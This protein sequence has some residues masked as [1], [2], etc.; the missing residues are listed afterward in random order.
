[1]SDALLI[2]MAANLAAA[3]AV[4]LVMILRTPARKMF[5][6]RLAYGLWLLVPLAALGVLLPSRVVTVT[7]RAASGQAAASAPVADHA[8]ALPAPAA[9]TFD[10]WPLALGVWIA[11]VVATLAWMSWRQA[12]FGRDAE[13]GLAGPAAVGV[14]KPRVITPSDFRRRY[15]AREQFVVLAHEETHI[16]RHD[17]RINALVT[18][19]RCVNWFNPMLHAMARFLRI[20]QE[21]AC[22]AQVIARHPKVRRAYAEAML[23]T[24]LAAQPLP[25]GCYWLPAGQHPLAERIRLLSRAA[26]DPRE[27]IL[28]LTLLTTLALAALGATWAAK[29]TRVQFV[30]LPAPSAPPPLALERI[31]AADPPPL[32]PMS[33]QT[34]RPAAPARVPTPPAPLDPGVALAQAQADA[35]A[36]PPLGG[37]GRDRGASEPGVDPKPRPQPEPRPRRILTAAGR[38]SVEPGSAVRVIASTTDGEG[39]A[40]MTDL[41]SFGS[42]HYYRTGTFI[43]S[44]SRER[45]FTRVVQSGER[46]WVTAGLDPRLDAEDSVTVEM[47]SG[48]TREVAL[49][50]GRAVTL[51]PLMRPET[52]K[53]R[54]GDRAA[55]GRADGD[56]DRSSRDA[57]RAYRDRCRAGSC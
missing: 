20:D 55:I 29:P 33:N 10:P 19:A 39:R 45:L 31:R 56:I 2:L 11:G 57:W 16:V 36:A 48:E 52:A 24:Q 34:P 44:G 13:A 42:Q 53:E 9:A 26:P 27:R 23:K 37:H 41:T 25:L 40:L 38:S 4:T 8:A 6:P 3:A 47:R 15:S 5:G 21:L 35:Q 51:T 54:A 18:A 46:L 28:G 50:N 14:L 7:V 32:V 1:M 22:D 12:R 17:T 49:P 43:A 30:E